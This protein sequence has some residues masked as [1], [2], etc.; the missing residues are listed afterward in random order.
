MIGL[1]LNFQSADVKN[2]DFHNH[3]KFY[4]FVYRKLANMPGQLSI[5]SDRIWRQYNY[6]Q[7]ESYE[8]GQVKTI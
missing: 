8:L 7:I 1:W 4:T 5:E 3:W 6:M 2:A